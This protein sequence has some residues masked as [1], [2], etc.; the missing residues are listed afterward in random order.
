M[1]KTFFVA[2]VFFFQGK[3][4]KDKNKRYEKRVLGVSVTFIF[5]KFYI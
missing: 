4:G 3:N 1:T 5:S 2:N